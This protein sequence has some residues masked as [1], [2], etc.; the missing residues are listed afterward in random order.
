MQRTSLMLPP[1][2]QRQAVRT[3]RQRGISLGE[4]VRQSL[5]RETATAYHAEADAF[6]AAPAVFHSG[7]GSLAA[8]HDSDLYGPIRR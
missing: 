5:V 2:L 1:E 7:V 8:D 4:L 6:W 3:A